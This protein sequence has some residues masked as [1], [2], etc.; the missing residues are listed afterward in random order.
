MESW[1]VYIKQRIIKPSNIIRARDTFDE[2]R[3]ALTGLRFTNISVNEEP[4]PTRL[5]HS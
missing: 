2:I 3:N 4:T 5:E 1:S